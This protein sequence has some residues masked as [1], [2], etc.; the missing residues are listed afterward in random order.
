[1]QN[2]PTQNPPTPIHPK[3]NLHINGGG[4]TIT[5]EEGG[6]AGEYKG[7]KG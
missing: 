1:M 5:G 2:N 4:A 6:A 3:L 7:K